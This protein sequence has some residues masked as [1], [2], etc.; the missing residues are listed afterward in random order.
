MKLATASLLLAPAAAFAPS[1][2]FV[3]K[4]ALFAE[5]E[6]ATEKVR[7]LIVSACRGSGD[8]LLEK[9]FVL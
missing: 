8:K 9:N 3:A 1:A 5:T 6:A 2:G 4:T 7:T